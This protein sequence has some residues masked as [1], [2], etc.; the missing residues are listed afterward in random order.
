[1]M[2]Y[3]FYTT[4]WNWIASECHSL[5]CLQWIHG[6]TT[7]LRRYE[8]EGKVK[9][10]H[11][12]SLIGWISSYPNPPWSVPGKLHKINATNQLRRT[13][14]LIT[15]QFKIWVLCM[16]TLFAQFIH[17]CC[18]SNPVKVWRTSLSDRLFRRGAARCALRGLL[19]HWLSAAWQQHHKQG[20]PTSLQRRGVGRYETV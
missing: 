5:R 15:K 20:V 14:L 10:N 18:R 17:S 11:A 2:T 16:L 1:M 7:V 8:S 6:R 3:W 4:K 12:R 13:D 9:N 19:A